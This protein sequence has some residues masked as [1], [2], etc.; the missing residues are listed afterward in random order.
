MSTFNELIDFTRS[1][2][3]TYLDSVV[4]GDELVTNGTF[5]SNTDG[6]TGYVATLSLSSNALRVTNAG[7]NGWAYQTITTVVGATYT[8][9]VE[10]VAK[11]AANFWFTVSSG[12]NPDTDRLAF[13]SI[14]TT[15]TQSL[16]FTAT[17][18]ST[19]VFLRV[20]GSSGNWIDFD[21]VSVKEIIGGQVSGTPLLRTAA[22]NEPRLEYDASGNPLGL[23]IEEARTNVAVQSN[24]AAGWNQTKR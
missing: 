19:N 6:W 12:G 24:F 2:T 8:V 21:N 23:L 20:N 9:S 16:T 22:I 10:V 5:D 11:N 7:N 4:Y 3:G 18:T 1:T 14:S 13:D 17:T 15:G